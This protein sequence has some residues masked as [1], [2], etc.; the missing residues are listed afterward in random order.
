[1]SRGMTVN[2]ESAAKKVRLRVRE[3]YTIELDGNVTIRMVSKVKQNLNY[4]GNIYYAADI[5]RSEIKTGT[6]GKVDKISITMK[7]GFVSWA[8][9]AATV[10]N[11]LSGCRCVVEEVHLDYPDD[12]PNIIF[13]GEID[14]PEFT[15]TEFKIT[16]RREAVDFEAQAPNETYEPTC[17]YEFKGSDGRCGYDGTETECDFTITRCDQLNNVT[18]FGGKPSI[19]KEMVPSG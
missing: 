1:M 6:D 14:E 7:N 5:K 12:P 13:D 9:Y 4:D 10:G 19:P 15:Y 3:L 2:Q 17:P 11:R 18:S 16:V 8:A